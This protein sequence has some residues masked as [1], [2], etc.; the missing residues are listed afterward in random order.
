[1]KFVLYKHPRTQRFAL[2]SVPHQFTVGDAVEILP[3]EHWFATRED[4]LASL[5]ELF[6][7][8]EAVTVN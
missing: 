2:I 1:V 4:A 6:D 5:P 8:G 3:A 7:R